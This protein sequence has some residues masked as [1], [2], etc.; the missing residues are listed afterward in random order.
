[1]FSWR[2]WMYYPAAVCASSL[3]LN[4]P[5]SSPPN[6]SNATQ[7]VETFLDESLENLNAFYAFSWLFLI[8]LLLSGN[9]AVSWLAPTARCNRSLHAVS[10][11]RGATFLCGLASGAAATTVSPWTN[12][13]TVVA[14]DPLWCFISSLYTKIRFTSVNFSKLVPSALKASFCSVVAI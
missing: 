1:M 11:K 14:R 5:G 12:R 2:G 8:Q 3:T 9:I 10:K 13:K 7:E 6:Q 4:S